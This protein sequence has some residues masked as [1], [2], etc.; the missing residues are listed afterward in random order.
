[1]TPGIAA[2]SASSRST[3]FGKVK[4]A[5]DCDGGCTACSTSRATRAG[6][7]YRSG[8]G[9]WPEPQTIAHRAR[10]FSRASGGLGRTAA[11]VEPALGESPSRSRQRQQ[12]TWRADRVMHGGRPSGP[13]PAASSPGGSSAWPGTH[14]TRA[15]QDFEDGVSARATS[16]GPGRRRRDRPAAKSS[17]GHWSCFRSMAARVPV[18]LAKS[19]RRPALTCRVMPISDGNRRRSGA[20]QDVS[21]ARR[22][23]RTGSI[24][25][26]PL[27]ATPS[28]VAPA[29][30][31]TATR[32]RAPGK[33]GS[34][35]EITERS[36]PAAPCRAAEPKGSPEPT[37][38]QRQ[39][40]GQ[41]TSLFVVLPRQCGASP[42]GRRQG[43]NA[44]NSSGTR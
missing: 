16:S 21:A 11:G 34:P 23:R 44:R 15:G 1:M 19:A 31:G 22:D 33:T 3:L 42:A 9:D 2:W 10:S 7:R 17:A 12:A 39:E 18:S 37:R 32:P 25:A 28:R 29:H 41:A 20:L 6:E 8:P 30:S 27:G 35:V 5:S 26:M 36:S 14:A 38:L 40:R 43:G 4:H 13:R 24:G